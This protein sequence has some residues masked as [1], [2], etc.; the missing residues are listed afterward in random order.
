[1]QAG[2]ADDRFIEIKDGLVPGDAVVTTGKR[3]LYTQWLTGGAKPAA[4]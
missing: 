2:A 3:E 4:D 1:V